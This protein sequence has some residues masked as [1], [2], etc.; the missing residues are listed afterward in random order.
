MPH[1]SDRDRQMILTED[2]WPRW[3]VLPVKRHTRENFLEL[4]CILSG[5][6]NVV[7]V[8][9]MFQLSGTVDLS[10]IPSVTYPDVD[11][12]LADGWRVD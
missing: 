12:L 4:G 1:P 10:T 8:A 2:D 6:L 5:S 11:A 7:R 9:N 3:P